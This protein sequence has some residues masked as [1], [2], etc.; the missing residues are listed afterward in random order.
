MILL[1]VNKQRHYKEE[2]VAAYKA[3]CQKAMDTVMG[4]SFIDR[5]MRRNSLVLSATISFVGSDYIRKINKEYREI[6]SVTDVLTFPL[7][8][9]QNG[10]LREAL[11]VSDVVPH[12]DG[13]TELPLGEVLIS[14]E[15]AEAQAKEYGHSI[16]REVAFLA[17]HAALH[18]VG[19]DHVDPA[20]E[21][22]MISEQ[23]KVLDEMGL[24]R[25]TSE[26][27]TGF[28]FSGEESQEETAS[29]QMHEILDHSGFVAI[30][31]RPNVGKST[32]L[33]QI[34][35]MKL[36]IVSPK[37][38][39]TRKN[40]RSVVNRKG[41]QI[42]FV[43]TPGIHRPKSQLAEY[44]VDVACRAAKDSDMILIL[45][46]ATQGSPSHVEVEV[47]KKAR[48]SGKKVILAINKADAVAKEALLPIIAQ[49]YR[50]YEFEAIIPISART[51]DGVE[52]LLDEIAGRLPAGS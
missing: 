19:F 16:E 14:L 50:L 34:S 33:N 21:K 49:Y 17:T 3:L 6:N 40:I 51:G 23:K 32:F 1:F 26:E 47:C 31:G 36:A 41:A 7:L 15:K 28:E 10:K 24:T 44:K 46:D 22:R 20:E 18:L 43:D 11:T 5:R 48:E 2:Q 39:T 12:A 13:I 27:T 29:D 25:E 35:G 37:P 8:D 30:I 52:E 42:I 9:M 38:Q 4:R 45:A